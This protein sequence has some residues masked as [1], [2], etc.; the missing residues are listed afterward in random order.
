M[1]PLQNLFVLVALSSLIG[2][3]TN[4]Y[5]VQFDSMPQGATLVCSGTNWGYTP[6]RLY[7]DESVKS[8]AYL[9]VSDCRAIWS[10]GVTATYPARLNIYPQGSTLITLPRPDAPGYSQDANFSL[11]IQNMQSQKRQAAAAEDAAL[12]AQRK[13]NKTTTCYNNFGVITCY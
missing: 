12:E 9:D 5:S 11:Q 2:C 1:K 13:N 4:K 7:Y 3:S 6:K 10:S 8:N